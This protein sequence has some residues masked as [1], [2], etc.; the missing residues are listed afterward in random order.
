[1]SVP[2]GRRL[3]HSG[4]SVSQ[5]WSGEHWIAKSSATSIPASLRRGDEAVEVL[6]GPELG[7]KRVVAALLGADRP[8]RTD[9][10]GVV[11]ERVVSALPVR[12]PDRMHR[13]EI[14]D[15]EA[16]LGEARQHPGDA[17]QPAERSRKQ[18]VPGAEPGE[19]AVDVHFERLG[20]RH[21]VTVTAVDRE[22][23]GRP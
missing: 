22:A 4:C 13:R 11:L 14:D 21:A 9:V 16:E 20:R 2:S 7:V 5:G 19:L 23:L 18:L 6:P 17:A 1:M 10:A 15:V 12:V 8:R 3:N